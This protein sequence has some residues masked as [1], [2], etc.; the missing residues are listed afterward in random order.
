MYINNLQLEQ[1]I[2]QKLSLAVS[3]KLI[4]E[5]IFLGFEYALQNPINL[6]LEDFNSY[7]Y[8]SPLLR[9]N[10]YLRLNFQ[11]K[12]I[13]SSYKNLNILKK[14]NSKKIYKQF[15]HLLTHYKLTNPFYSSLHIMMNTGAKANWNQIR[16]LIGLRGFLM[17]ARGFL[18]KIPIMQSF[19][20]GL[21]AYEYFI[22]CYGARKGILDTSLK[23]ANAGYLTRRLVE[24]IQE[25]TI[26]EYSC[27]TTNFFTFKWNISYK[28]FLDLPFYLLL[29]GKTIQNNFKNILTGKQIFLQ[30]FFINTTIFNKLKILLSFN[31]NLKL[32]LN[33]IKLCLSGRTFCS[34]C[35]GFSFS[36][37]TFLSQGVG[38]LIGESIGEPVTQ[39]TLRTF[40]TGG[41][42]S[43]SL[44][45]QFFLKNNLLNTFLLYKKR[46]FKICKKIKFLINYNLLSLKYLNLEYNKNFSI[47]LNISKKQNNIFKIKFYS[48]YNKYN[49]N[50]IISYFLKYKFLYLF[51]LKSTAIYSFKFPFYFLL[52]KFLYQR[53]FYFSSTLILNRT[54]NDLLFGEVLFKNSL[55][56][57]V[58]NNFKKWIILCL[59]KTIILNKCIFYYPINI[60][61]IGL[62]CRTSFNYRYNKF[63][64]KNYK[65]LNF[66]SKK[67]L[68]KKINNFFLS[69][70]INYNF[71]NKFLLLKRNSKFRLNKEIINLFGKNLKLIMV[72]DSF[73]IQL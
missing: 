35:F 67:Y 40:H 54:K 53:N 18:F 22:S 69:I 72:V 36:Q 65:V 55:Q 29:Y 17:N 38:V 39:M 46:N 51:Y 66:T 19:N 9:K 1:R 52:I 44:Q 28:G 33:S 21:K 23:T 47:V 24:S 45:T 27:G 60:N 3:S 56:Y 14:I 26:K 58:L 42:S 50:K 2:I 30:G 63:F 7:F 11:F 59:Q 71:K 68:N 5:L 43:I 12:D 34:K 70:Y 31:K 57:I 64:I 15:F 62:L 61:N 32:S 8:L 13:F 6:N 4:Q 48:L 37:K 16:Q 49:L 73:N 10:E 41:I 20:K 25:S